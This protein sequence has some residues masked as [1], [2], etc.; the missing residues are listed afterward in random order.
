MPS[1][2]PTNEGKSLIE[3]SLSGELREL[4]EDDF[5]V[6]LTLVLLPSPELPSPLWVAVRAGA[7]G[8][9]GMAIHV[10]MGNWRRTSETRRRG[11]MNRIRMD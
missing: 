4:G 11:R 10:A 9:L 5:V 1:G 8:L 7:C 2:I 6:P 3:A